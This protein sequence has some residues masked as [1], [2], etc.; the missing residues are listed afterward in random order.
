MRNNSL[1]E[2]AEILAFVGERAQEG[3][4]TLEEV[5]TWADIIIGHCTIWATAQELAA[6]YGQSEHNV[7]S[8][9]N[10]RYMGKPKRRVYY[11]FNQFRKIVPEGWKC[12]I[13]KADI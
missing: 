12:H 3:H 4:M 8:V 10:R 13:Q 6:F 11:S 7:R 2:L 9:I 1:N 5:H